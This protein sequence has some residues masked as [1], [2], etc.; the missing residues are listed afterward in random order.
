VRGPA[1]RQCFAIRQFRGDRAP[2]GVLHRQ[3]NVRSVL[4]ADDLIVHDQLHVARGGAVAGLRSIGPAYAVEI[5]PVAVG[6]GETPGDVRVAAHD[7][8]GNTR[9]RETGDVDLAVDGIGVGI[10]HARAE[11]DVGCAQRQVHV[12]GDDRATI[13]G[14]RAGDGEVVAAGR[15]FLG[16]GAGV[17]MLGHRQPVQVEFAR[18]GQAHVAA[19]GAEQRR[20]PFGAVGG[21]QRVQG[22]RQ[23]LPDLPQR[24]L[25]AV[26]FVL[27]VEEHRVADQRGIGRLPVARFGAQQQVGPGLAAQRMHAGVH[28]L[29]VCGELRH[30]RAGDRLQ[31]GLHA[32]AQAMHARALVYLQRPLADELGQLARRGPAQQVHFEEA[33]LP[34]HESE[35]A[36]GVICIRGSNGDDALGIAFDLH[37]RAQSRQGEFAIERGQAAAQHPPRP[38]DDAEEDEEE[39][40]RPAGEPASPLLHRR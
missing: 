30:A 7:H 31:A 19:R 29:G 12:V 4:H 14:E 13:V 22:R 16:F 20:I 40:Q 26:G 36:R 38:A 5:E 37:G 10:E 27:Q 18:A 33:F 34:V 32:C 1:Q 15:G 2:L 25:A 23:Q 35:C 17:G 8:R 24:Q 3:V 6:I 11:P 28:A 39:R 9:Q 21:D